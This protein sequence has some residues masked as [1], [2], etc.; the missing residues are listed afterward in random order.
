MSPTAKTKRIIR[1]RELHQKVSLSDAT[2]WRM[3]KKGDFPQRVQIGPNAVGWIEGEVDLWI[4]QLTN[5]R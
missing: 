2:I 5:E 1:K 3:E 4:D